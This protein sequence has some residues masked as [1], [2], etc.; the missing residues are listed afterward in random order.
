MEGHPPPDSRRKLELPVDVYLEMICIKFLSSRSLGDQRRTNATTTRHKTRVAGR[1]RG[2][3][4]SLSLSLFRFSRR[5]F[6]TIDHHPLSPL[7]PPLHLSLLKSALVCLPSWVITGTRRCV[8]SPSHPERPFPDSTCTKNHFRRHFFFATR[9]NPL[10]VSVSIEILERYWYRLFLNSVSQRGMVIWMV[11]HD[12]YYFF[13]GGDIFFRPIDH[14]H[15]IVGIR[16]REID[17]VRL[18]GEI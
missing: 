15:L 5:D 4:N 10:S 7:S 12:L 2:V 3:Q 16:V 11:N 14:F 18:G 1:K 6:R 13:E 8:S 17:Q 9:S